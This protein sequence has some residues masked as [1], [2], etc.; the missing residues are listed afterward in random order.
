ME[1]LK[2]FCTVLVV[3]LFIFILNEFWN[4]FFDGALKNFVTNVVLSFLVSASILKN[5]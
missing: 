5:K 3:V 2:N 4:Q 1:I